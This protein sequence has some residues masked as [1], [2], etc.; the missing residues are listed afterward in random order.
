[1]GRSSFVVCENKSAVGLTSVAEIARTGV[2]ESI[3]NLRGIDVK[4]IVMLTGDNSATAVAVANHVAID[5]VEA[6][7]LPEG[8]VDYVKKLKGKDNRVLIVGD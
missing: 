6:G 8:K 4:N 2:A 5:E 7:L 1:M 3:S